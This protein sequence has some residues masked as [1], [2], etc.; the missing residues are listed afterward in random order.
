M[1][2]KDRIELT[3]EEKAERRRL[4]GLAGQEK[5]PA[6]CLKNPVT[7]PRVCHDC[8]DHEAQAKLA[9]DPMEGISG[10]NGG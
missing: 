10:A 8:I 5:S 1:S 4:V 3:E 9:A 6:R 2:T 7:W